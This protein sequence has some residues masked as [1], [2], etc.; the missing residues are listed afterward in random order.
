MPF[1]NKL[2]RGTNFVPFT[3]KESV[4]MIDTITIQTNDRL[5]KEA[6]RESISKEKLRSYTISIYNRNN[7]IVK[8]KFLQN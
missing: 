7:G 3:Q 4:R 1:Y 6:I 8:K 5:A 2:I